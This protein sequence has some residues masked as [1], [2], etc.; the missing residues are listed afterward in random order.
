MVP[1]VRIFSFLVSEDGVECVEKHI[2]S[3]G[4]AGI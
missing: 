1:V 3:S 2:S 4:F